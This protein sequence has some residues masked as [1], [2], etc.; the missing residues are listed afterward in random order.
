MDKRYHVYSNNNILEI[1][2]QYNIVK[3]EKEMDYP[4]KLESTK[5]HWGSDRWWFICPLMKNGR[6]CYPRVGKL[7]L[8]T[9]M[10]IFDAGIVTT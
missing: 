3:I 10:N 1:R 9:V 4:I 5:L 2:L 6:P 8:P 7:Y